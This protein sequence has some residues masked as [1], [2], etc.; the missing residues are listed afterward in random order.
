MKH[1][2]KF[3]ESKL[4]DELEDFCKEYLAY[5]TD[6][7]FECYVNSNN[8]NTHITILE[9]DYN[10]EFFP[11]RS[12]RFYWNEIEDD[13]IPFLQILSEKYVIAHGMV[14]LESYEPVTTTLNIS[15]KGF[16]IRDVIN[17]EIP[18]YATCMGV[19]LQIDRKISHTDIR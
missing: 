16:S 8:I 10:A 15:N 9:R 14:V 18:E 12:K 4:G 11:G 3:N 1:L 19:T 7:K 13:F 2:R 5:L 6:G 17:G